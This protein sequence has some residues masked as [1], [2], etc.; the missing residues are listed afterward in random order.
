MRWTDKSV[1]RNFY[2]ISVQFI[3]IKSILHLTNRHSYSSNKVQR[4]FIT[5]SPNLIWVSDITHV[6]VKNIDYSIGVIIDLYASWFL[7]AMPVRGTAVNSNPWPRKFAAL[8]L[9][10]RVDIRHLTNI[11]FCVILQTGYVDFPQSMW[12][13]KINSIEVNYEETSCHAVRRYAA[14]RRWMLF[15]R[16]VQNHDGKEC[17]SAWCPDS[18]M[19]AK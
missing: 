15:S 5:E 4:K 19:S 8:L 2:G 17:C 16:T 7:Q 9:V 18:G 14:C 11:R 6:Y 12:F 1:I 3:P 13:E 10:C